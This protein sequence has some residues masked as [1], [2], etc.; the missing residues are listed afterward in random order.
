M[1]VTL[2]AT[3]AADG[4]ELRQV[5]VHFLAGMPGLEDHTA[6]RLSAVEGLPIFWLECE[7]EPE[8]ALPVVMAAHVQPGYTVDLNDADAA[9]LGLTQAEDALV[10]VTL[11]I[12]QQLGSATANL[13][14]PIV[15][16]RHTFAA[17]QVIVEGSTHS[18]RH[19]IDSL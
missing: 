6:Y 19:P 12:S 4:E 13:I 3:P 15:I 17:K 14:A 10:L 2:A 9:A 7:A 11:T 5:A 18:L 16:N 8:I 1:T